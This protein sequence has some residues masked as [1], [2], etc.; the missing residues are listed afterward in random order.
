MRKP[1]VFNNKDEDL[2]QWQY[3]LLIKAIREGKPL[4][5]IGIHELQWSVFEYMNDL[6]N[7]KY[8]DKQHYLNN[9]ILMR[10]SKLLSKINPIAKLFVKCEK[11]IYTPDNKVGCEYSKKCE[12]GKI[13]SLNV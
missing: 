5:L 11:D 8:D 3:N 7:R 9:L 2:I 4:I 12:L 1:K 10:K 6:L 13:I